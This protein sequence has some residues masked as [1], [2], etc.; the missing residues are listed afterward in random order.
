MNGSSALA[1][2]AA[3][4]WIALAIAIGATAAAYALSYFR[5]L[6]KIA[7][8]PDIVP[9]S[10]GARWLPKFGNSLQTAIVQFS[11]R[12]LFRSRQHRVVLA[13]YVGVAFAAMIF[14]LKSSVAR[15]ISSPSAAN[16]WHQPGMPLLASSIMLM[17]FWVLGVRVVFSLPMDLPANWIFRITPVREGAD[18]CVAR[19][20][21][22]LV[23]A[24]L[25]V[26]LGSAVLFLSIWP[27]RAA[28]G[29]LL[30]LALLGVILSELFLAGMQKIPFTC[31]WLPGKSNFHITFWLCIALLTQL[32]AR[33]AEYERR[34]LANPSGY[35]ILLAVLLV[36]AVCVRWRNQSDDTA[37]VFEEVPAWKLITL[38]LP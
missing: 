29:H 23:L 26:S 20:R 8:A 24:V 17:G 32:V 25:P 35:A 38:K 21:S 10:G 7:E 16:P 9:G 5:T 31:S 37:L 14:L 19:R 28:L 15:Q 34:L 6:R 2:L 3:R 33:A 12:T 1:P 18:C 36:V 13:F 11:I 4:A 30:L 22:L 27:W